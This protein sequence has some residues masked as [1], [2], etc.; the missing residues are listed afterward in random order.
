LVLGATQTGYKNEEV[1]WETSIQTNLGI[2]LALWENKWTFSAD[3]YNTEKQDMLFSLLLPPS[4]GA[5][6]NGTVTLN[7]GNM[8]NRGMEFATNYAH[9][10][11]NG[12]S[13]NIGGTFA[14]N[15]NEVTQMSG[16]NKITYLSQGTVVDGVPNADKVTALSEGYEAGAFFLMPTDGVVK[17]QEELEDY[18]LL[19]PSAKLGDLRYVDTN[20]DSILDENDRVYGGS[21]VPDFEIGLNLTFRYKGFDLGMNWYGSFGTEVINASRIF[22]YMSGTHK[23]LLYQWSPLNPESDVAANRGRDHW[24]SREFTDRWVEDGT[25]IRLRNAV[26]GYTFPKSLIKRANLTKL[27]VYISAQ[28]P[29]IITKYSGFDPELGGYDPDGAGGDPNKGGGRNMHTRGIDK[30]NY[31]IARMFRGGVQFSF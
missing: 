13:M 31:P 25:F 5:G 1:K 28:N 9:R 8:V 4:T 3:F 17:T 12:F 26:V 16:S 19:R 24:N 10:G 27:R 29:L 30:G 7:V 15:L 20:N 18:Q 14:T 23:G 11:K 21:G 2:D 6:K 22:S